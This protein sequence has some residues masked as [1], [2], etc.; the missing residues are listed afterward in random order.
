MVITAIRINSD[1]QSPSQT[2]RSGQEQNL[3]WA[4]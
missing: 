2:K 1:K 4:S 3:E